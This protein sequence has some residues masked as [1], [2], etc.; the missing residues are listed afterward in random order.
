ML[1]KSSL[2]VK[3]APELEFM[4][5]AAPVQTSA[6]LFK[7]VQT[8]DAPVQTGADAYEPRRTE[9]DPHQVGREDRQD[10]EVIAS[11]EAQVCLLEIDKAVRDM[12]VEFLTSQ[13]AAA[14]E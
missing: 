6:H 12:H 7:R 1:E 8:E 9:A 10:T 13:N 11:L 3:V 5:E 4:Q 2:L 14:Q